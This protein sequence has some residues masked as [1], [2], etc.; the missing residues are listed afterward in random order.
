MPS[1]VPELRNPEDV[2]SESYRKN[3]SFWG[4]CTKSENEDMIQN[5]TRMKNEGTLQEFYETHN[6]TDVFGILEILA[7]RKEMKWTYKD[8][9]YSILSDIFYF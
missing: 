6:K 5:V 2:I 3:L 9:E 7:A 4:T 8:N 1:H